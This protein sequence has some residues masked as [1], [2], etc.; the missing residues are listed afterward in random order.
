MKDEFN[1][2]TPEI[3]SSLKKIYKKKQLD[4]LA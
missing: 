2:E 3:L 4:Q 1:I